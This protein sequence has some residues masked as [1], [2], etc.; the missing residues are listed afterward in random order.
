MPDLDSIIQYNH[1]VTAEILARARAI[2]A[3]KWIV[4]RA[5]GKWSPAQVVEH[6]TKSYES[7]RK[8]LVEPITL[9]LVGSVKAW[10]ARAFFLPGLFAAGDFSQEG[11][12]SPAF[13]YP[14]EV[15]APQEE[16][17]PRFEASSAGLEADLHEAVAA[18]R[19]KIVHPFFGGLAPADLLQFVAIHGKH[20]AR[21]IV[22]AP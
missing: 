5:P 1:T 9:S 2:P 14:N 19:E 16:L 21:Q 6:V 18:Q 12:K 11:L 22:A 4:P 17:L 8:M 15:P 10:A 7:H 20:H 3:E 13:I